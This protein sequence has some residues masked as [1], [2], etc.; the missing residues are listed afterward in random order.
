M[1]KGVLDAS[2]VDEEAVSN[3]V[4]SEHVFVVQSESA[5][6]ISDDP[7]SRIRRKFW[8]GVLKVSRLNLRGASSN[9]PNTD[10]TS[11]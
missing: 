4:N 11:V 1:L 7:V 3:R 9:I 5:T 2:Y 6:H 10:L 8:G